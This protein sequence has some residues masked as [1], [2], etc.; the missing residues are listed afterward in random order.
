MQLAGKSNRIAGKKTRQTQAKINA[1]AGKST[2][3]IAGKNTCNSTQNYVQ[4]QAICYHIA[5]KFTCKLLVILYRIAAIFVCDC[6]GIFP[7]FA[8]IFACVWRVFLPAILV[9][10]RKWIFEILRKFS[11][12]KSN[13]FFVLL[14]ILRFFKKKSVVFIENA[15]CFKCYSRSTPTFAGYLSFTR[16]E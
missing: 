5:G 7:P 9:L 3:I 8:V 2:R 14:I 12:T 10:L 15:L 11:P 4:L 13:A 1:K 6:A 16:Y